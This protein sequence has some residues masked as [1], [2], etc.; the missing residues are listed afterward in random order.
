MLDLRQVFLVETFSEVPMI[1]AGF[2]N[3]VGF[4]RTGPECAPVNRLG[5][6]KKW[7]NDGKTVPLGPTVLRIFDIFD[8]LFI[9]NKESFCL[10]NAMVSCTMF[11]EKKVKSALWAYRRALA[12]YS[13][14]AWFAFGA[15][16][17]SAFLGG[18]PA[19]HSVRKGEHT[20]TKR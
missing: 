18:N 1:W 11:D 12:S 9:T 5:E 20:W 19:F 3:P 4:C 14:P 7:K 6:R 15:R 8:S 13:T 17:T 10:T 16:A 2:V